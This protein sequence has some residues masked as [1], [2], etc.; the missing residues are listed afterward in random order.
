MLFFLQQSLYQKFFFKFIQFKCKDICYSNSFFYYL[1]Y[2]ITYLIIRFTDIILRRFLKTESDQIQLSFPKVELGNYIEEQIE[3][4]DDKE[5]LDSEIQI[6]QN[7]LDFSEVRAKEAMVPRAELVA[8]E[9]NT[10]IKDQRIFLL[11]QDFLKY[12]FTKI[13]L[14]KLWD[15]FMFLI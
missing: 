6:F 4:T 11:K 1:F 2:P 9:E 13:Q 7:A 14:I 8:V 12:Q 10:P 15:M 5:S 3:S